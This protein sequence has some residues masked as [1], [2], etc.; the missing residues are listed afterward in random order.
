MA[1]KKKTLSKN[2]LVVKKN[3]LND[4]RPYNM[5]LQEL[6]FF[7]IY[8][9]KINPQDEKSR[10][11]RFPLSEFQSIMDVG[12]LNMTHTKNVIDG[13]LTKLT[14]IPDEK[15]TGMIRFQIFKECKIS[16]DSDGEWYVEID[17][18]DR[19]LPLMFNFKGYFFRYELWNTLRLK[20]VNQ[21]R[22]Y[23]I[24][25]QY[26]K[27]GHRI[28]P[29]SELKSL[30]GINEA[31]YPRFN[32][33]REHVIDRCQRALTEYTD[34]SFTYESYSK[35]GNGGKILALKLKK[36][37][38]TNFV[39]PLMLDKFI[40]NYIPDEEPVR[41]E[42]KS[43]LSEKKQ[44]IEK[45]KKHQFWRYA[46]DIAKKTKKSNPNIKASAER[47]AIGIMKKWEEIGCNTVSDLVASG[48][49]SADI[50]NTSYDIAELEEMVYGSSL[51]YTYSAD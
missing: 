30:L 39:D 24:L 38:N 48:E 4:I 14:S 3:D 6:R 31:E 5:G 10:V 35:K 33:F 13:L 12:R 36:K 51:T 22:M 25:K 49:I 41:R 40:D 26:E 16:E 21:L 23:E 7:T 45:A 2:Y 29:I 19:A 9:S 27:V 50:N 1:K 8:L 17:A 37:K 42:E 20:S 28:L 47:Y 43:K 34:I 11:V 15:G 18:H 44:E 32:R 46:I